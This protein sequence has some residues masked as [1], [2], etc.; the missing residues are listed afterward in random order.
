MGIMV[1][2]MRG[3]VGSEDAGKGIGDIF[4]VCALKGGVRKAKGRRR[5]Q[6]GHQTPTLSDG[7]FWRAVSSL[8]DVFKP[9]IIPDESPHIFCAH[10][11][12]PPPPPPSC[13][14]SIRLFLTLTRL[15]ILARV[16]M[17]A[18]RAWDDH[19]LLHQCMEVERDAHWWHVLTSLGIP[20]DNR[21]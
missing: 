5:V 15:R 12:L 21:G 20:F 14:V 1:G 6:C 18:A 17:Y 10:I 3:E 7:E 9:Q 16:G 2:G 4:R 19:D 13:H 8:Y 11:E